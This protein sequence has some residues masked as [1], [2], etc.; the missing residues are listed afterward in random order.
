M[1]VDV[2]TYS[3]AISHAL[4]YMGAA[5]DAQT[6][7][8]ARRAVQLAY[9]TMM[10]Q[11]N[12][13]YYYHVGHINT[14]ASYDTGTI[15]YTHSSKTVTLTGGTWPSW[16]ADGVIVIDSVPYPIASRTDGTSI[17]LVDANN[18]GANVAALTEF[19]I[20]R[21]AYTLPVDFGRMDKVYRM[22]ESSCLQYMTPGDFI[23]IQAHEVT[24]SEPRHYTI[25]SDTNR[26]GALALRLHPAPDAI[27]PLNMAYRRR[28]RSLR[29]DSYETGTV[30]TSSASTTLTGIGT[31]W[32]SN[33]VGCM[34]RIAQNDDAVPTGLSGANPFWL[35]RSIIAYV[36]PTSL[37]LDAAPGETL[38][39]VKYSISDPVDI[40]S[41]AM[42]VYFIRE[43]ERQCR[44]VKRMK[45][46]S[47]EEQ[48]QYSLS[49]HAALEADNRRFDRQAAGSG[50]YVIPSLSD[51]PVLDDI[52]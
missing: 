40:E 18:P 39:G 24:T 25:T 22:N 35:E 15:E 41:G 47:E 43:V 49:L 51:G 20:Y 32:S 45:P 12:W 42:L 23:G 37:T 50:L 4:D 2:W 5:T 7:R 9:S 46:A 28:P 13:T 14:V 27:Y 21:E 34:V 16:A 29:I 17:I 11:R 19:V 36:S 3:D 38:T 52:E 1:K 8:F 44:A 26:H 33:L 31:S 6:E 48:E 30:T 10:N